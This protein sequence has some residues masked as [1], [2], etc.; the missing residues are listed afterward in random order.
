MVSAV[1]HAAITMAAMMDAWRLHNG[2]RAAMPIVVLIRKA[3]V[4]LAWQG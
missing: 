4:K 3:G 1:L 2:R